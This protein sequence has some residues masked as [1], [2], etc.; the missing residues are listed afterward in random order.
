MKSSYRHQG[1]AQ[2]GPGFDKADFLISQMRLVYD[3]A[4][5]SSESTK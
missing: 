5:S 2:Q 3:Q 1:K 4:K